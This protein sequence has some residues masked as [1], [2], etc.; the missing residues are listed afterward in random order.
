MILADEFLVR[1]RSSPND[2][3]I[4][5]T[6]EV[7]MRRVLLCLGLILIVLPGV[8]S[9]QSG[10]PAFQ[11]GYLHPQL[12]QDGRG[13]AGMLWVRVSNSGHDLV[14][15]KRRANGALMD[16]VK[17]NSGNGDVRYVAHPE[18]RPGIAAGPPGAAGV[19]WFDT[20]GRLFVAISRDG[21]STFG[22]AIEVDA[23][24]ADPAHPF[25]DVAFDSGGTLYVTWVSTRDGFPQLMAARIEG[26]RNAVVQ[27]L[28]GQFDTSVCSGSRPDLFIK[29]RDLTISF[30]VAGADGFRD[31]HR[32]Q[33]NSNLKPSQPQRM[34]PPMW[35]V[36]GCPTN[37][38]ATTREF[39]W[40]LDG[41]TGQPR[42]MEAFSPTATP[43]PI[44]AATVSAPYAPQLVEG[45]EGPSW[46]LYLPGKSFGQVL[47]RSGGSWRVLVDEVPYFCS[48]ITLLEGQLLMVGDKEGVLWMEATAVN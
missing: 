6:M 20:S 37:G 3:F 25:S 21:A 42:L 2:G 4:A 15:A 35:K 12:V 7:V 39:T 23:G 40:F 48:D 17:V 31:V 14:I 43:S 26:D 28:T 41:S 46:M 29:G 47:V 13:N 24:H 5:S 33:T 8:T 19:S 18:G 30:R 38:V 45:S 36:G 11:R 32:I 44:R 22:R 34:G 1:A 16:P 27:N 9:A 10:R